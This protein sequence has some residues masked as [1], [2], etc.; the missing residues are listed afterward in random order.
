VGIVWPY[1]AVATG[2]GS[3]P[4][5]HP[6][7]ASNVVAGEFAA[8]PH[9]VELPARGPGSDSVG[10]SAAMLALVDRAFEVETTTS[11]WR[12]GHAGQSVLRRAH[13]WLSHDLESLEEF[14]ATHRGPIKVQVLGP[15]TMAARVEDPAGE[16]LLRDHGAVAEVA[17]AAASAYS[18][19][20]MRMQHSFPHA[21]VLVQVNEPDV[22]AVLLGHV[23][24]SSGRL[25]HRSLEPHV[26]QA[27]LANVIDGIRAVGA[28]AGVRCFMPRPPIQL[29]LDAGAQFLCVDVT[30]ALP[31]DDALP[32]AW[33]NEVGLLLGCVPISDARVT[34]SSASA[35]IRRFMEESGFSEV[36]AHVAIT[37]T[38]GLANIDINAARRVIAA[39]IRVGAVLR[40]EETGNDR[41]Q[42]NQREATHG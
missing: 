25:T 16:A 29:F 24:T 34:D 19:L 36:P 8:M 9:V 15:V 12:I 39:C 27:R 10:R 18:D 1:P 17:A 6:H 13:S 22:P 21:E 35:P 3:M 38:G 5:T 32:Q 33:E 42:K 26:V 30:Q 28:T 7:E 11:G 41:A 23:R 14:A 20:V 4:G 2:V 37:P 40:G 31:F